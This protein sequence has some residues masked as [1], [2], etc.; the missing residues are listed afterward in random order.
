VQPCVA[1]VDVRVE[2]AQALLL[3]PVHRLGCMAGKG[4][5]AAKWTS[6]GV[7]AGVEVVVVVGVVGVVVGKVHGTYGEKGHTDKERSA[8]WGAPG[9]EEVLVS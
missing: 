4:L 8:D 9:E 3:S 1:V 5:G 6:M 7:A 2:R